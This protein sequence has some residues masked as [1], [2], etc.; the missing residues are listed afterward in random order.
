M[1]PPPIAPPTPPPTCY[2][3]PSAVSAIVGPQGVPTWVLILL[4]V[5]TAIAIITAL[6]FLIPLFDTSNPSAQEGSLPS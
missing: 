4:A 2:P 3:L 5:G 6:L 1:T